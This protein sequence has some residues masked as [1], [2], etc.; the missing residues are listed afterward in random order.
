MRTIRLTLVLITAILAQHALAQ[1][2][3]FGGLGMDQGR[4]ILVCANQDLMILGST[5]SDIEQAANVYLLRADTN[6]Q[7]IW[8]ASLGGHGVEQAISVVETD[9][10]E[11]LVLGNTSDSDNNGYD[12]VLWKVDAEGQLLWQHN[13]GDAQWNFANR[14]IKGNANDYWITGHTINSDNGSTDPLL[15]RIS[16]EGIALQYWNYITDEEDEFVDLDLLEDGT[17]LISGN[18]CTT[19]DT[20]TCW[21]KILDDTG[22]LIA[23]NT[24]GNDTLSAVLRETIVHDDFIVHCGHT[25]QNGVQSSY[26]RRLHLDGTTDWERIEIFSQDESYL[27][28]TELDGYYFTA[29]ASRVTGSGESDGILYR[30]NEGGWYQDAHIFQSSLNSG[31]YDI[32][33]HPNGDLFAVG[34]YTSAEQDIAL[35]VYKQQSHILANVPQPAPTFVD[36]FT[37]GIGDY[38]PQL[39]IALSEY[40]NWWGQ[41]IE[42]SQL[43]P[44]YIRIDFFTDGSST[45]TKICGPTGQMQR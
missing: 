43:S 39:A 23:F 45:A 10:E 5:A 2:F 35:L 1:N 34:Y 18:T 16:S 25:L 22:A 8:S 20:C 7:C 42:P 14:L 28:V 40:Y 29:T 6:L 27:S 3:A 21:I 26:L 32:A 11:F 36:C 4:E 9:E 17:R 12:I 38:R 37:V 30:R 31:F 24:F 19:E 15:I 13:Y 33:F 41:K 44:C